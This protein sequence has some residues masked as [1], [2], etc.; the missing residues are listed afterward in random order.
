MIIAKRKRGTHILNRWMLKRSQSM[1]LPLYPSEQTSLIPSHPWRRLNSGLAAWRQLTHGHSSPYR[2]SFCRRMSDNRIT[3]Y[4]QNPE[5]ATSKP[6]QRTISFQIL[7]V[8]GCGRNFESFQVS[9][10]NSQ[11][12]GRIHFSIV[13]DTMWHCPVPVN[14]SHSWSTF[15]SWISGCWRADIYDSLVWEIWWNST[16]IFRS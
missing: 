3:L 11:H 5:F 2:V 12:S 13:S 9:H 7:L 16:C 8:H 15:Q 14:R 6:G 10:G 4:N 1:Q